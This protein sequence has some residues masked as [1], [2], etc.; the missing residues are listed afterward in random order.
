MDGQETNVLIIGRGGREHALGWKLRQSPRCGR[1]YFA[2]GNGGTHEVGENVDLPI[3]PVTDE[4]ADAIARFCVRNVIGLV[5]IGPEDPLA[6]GLVDKLE[7]RLVDHTLVFGPNQRA[8]RIEADK[9]YAKG[10]MRDAGIPTAAY[11]IF[12]DFDEAAI[13]AEKLGSCV[14]KASGLAKGKGA[15][16]CA[17]PSHAFEALCRCMR[18]KEFGEAGE[19]VVI[20]ERL[21]GPEIS[22][23]ALVNGRT[24]ALFHSSQD[25]KPVGKGNTGPNT[26][27]MGAYSPTPWVEGDLGGNKMHN[28]INEI[29][30]TTLNA[31]ADCGIQYTGVLYVGLM[32]TKNGPKVFEYNC[33]FGDPETQALLP[34][35]KS[36]LLELLI[37]TCDGKLEQVSLDWDPRACVC[38]V[39]ASGGYP[40]EY[41]KGLPITGIDKIRSDRVVI[42]HSGTTRT[43]NGQLVTNGG[44][45]FGVCAMDYRLLVAQ[46]FAN[47]ACNRIKIDHAHFRPDIG[48]KALG[49]TVVG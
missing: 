4:N 11:G 22:V 9:A 21:T 10:L 49:Q 17:G 45:V 35:L 16:V 23:T 31:L 48:S 46:A 19:T 18:D 5:I 41:E 36:D 37:A 29:V 24:F 42:F 28:Q 30:S 13:Y 2:P 1:I 38:T 15:I 26:G 27:G 44:R 14:V 25:H 7:E 39:I 47:D 20:E 3:E 40:G 34:R 32:L 8:A 33:R 6:H 12:T 43:K